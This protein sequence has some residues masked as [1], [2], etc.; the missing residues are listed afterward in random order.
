MSSMRNLEPHEMS[1]PDRVPA[2]ARRLAQYHAVELPEDRIP[3]LF[4]TIDRWCALL[5]LGLAPGASRLP[6]KLHT[7]EGQLPR[8]RIGPVNPSG[9][10]A[11]GHHLVP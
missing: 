5:A 2:V 7:G 9:P 6:L 11:I 1:E 4:S 3:N 8:C 10:P